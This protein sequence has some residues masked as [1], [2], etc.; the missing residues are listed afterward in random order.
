MRYPYS[1]Q[2]LPRTNITDYLVLFGGAGVIR[3]RLIRAIG[4]LRRRKS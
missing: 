3:Y 2:C 1:V 4:A